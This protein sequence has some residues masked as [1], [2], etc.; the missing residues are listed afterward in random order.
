MKNAKKLLCMLSAAAILSGCAAE[1]DDVQTI[2]CLA[3]PETNFS[4]ATLP[5]E[6]TTGSTESAGEDTEI[7]ITCLAE[8]ETTFSEATLPAETTADSTESAAITEN[9]TQ[10][11]AEVQEVE[12]L[13]KAGEVS[14]SFE[15]AL[16]KEVVSADNNTVISPLSVKIALNM[17]A[18]GA[19]NDTEKEMLEILGYASA[20]D[21]T[22]ESSRLV[23]ELNR[24]NGSLTLSNSVWTDIIFNDIGDN[25]KSGL[26]D[27]FNAEF[28]SEDL[29]D[30]KIVG[31]LNGW[32]NK[33]TNGLIPQMIS[34]PFDESTVMLLVNA[35]YFNN[36]WVREFDPYDFKST[37]YGAKGECDY[38]PMF[39]ESRDISYG[40]ND[41][42]RSVSLAYKDGSRMNLYLPSSD[43]ESVL[44]IAERLSPDELADATNMTYIDSYVNVFMPKFECEYSESLTDT[45]KRLGMSVV[46]DA[47]RSDF[48]GMLS[49]NSDEKIYISDVIHAAKIKCHEKGT[50]A[51]AATIVVADA[52]AMVS[53]EQPIYFTANKP[54]IYEIVS[55]S[56]D[57]L[58]IGVISGF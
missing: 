56:G 46:F 58:F 29:S 51:A 4:E 42:F 16:L 45:L 41:I 21:M 19:E 43:T 55:P 3:E 26:K 37:F 7:T 53:Y 35:L 52:A 18:L 33:N 48:S 30:E 15:Y 10:S 27:I 49:E 20:E 39:L 1:G 28:F 11:A 36:Q 14:K 34:I 25:Y 6:T 8:P 57:V 12:S 50:E 47:E 31:D 40:E 38:E 17:A 9:T 2:T 32:I 13:Y 22:D 54:F 44:D 23:T 5:A 24:D